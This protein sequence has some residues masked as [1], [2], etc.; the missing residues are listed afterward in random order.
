[1]SDV[2]DRERQTRLSMWKRLLNAG[3]PDD[4]P[5]SLLRQIDI[6]GGRRVSELTRRGQIPYREMGQG[7][8]WLCCTRTDSV[9]LQTEL[10]SLLK[11]M[12]L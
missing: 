2:I 7:F 6:Y 12:N 5:A 11:R 3:G 4:V 9:L 1:V 10:A 8:P